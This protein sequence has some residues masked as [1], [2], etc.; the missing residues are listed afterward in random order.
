VAREAFD[1]LIDAQARLEQAS[2]GRRYRDI[3][4]QSA[5]EVLG[6]D[7]SRAAMLADTVDIWPPFDDSS[8]ALARLARVAPLVALT[9]S[10]R[11]H[12]AAV[13]SALGGP[14]VVPWAHWLCAEDTGVYKPDPRVWDACAAA[15]GVTAGPAW[16]HVSAYADYDLDVASR[17]GLTTVYVERPH[18]RP[19]PARWTIPDLTALARL[20]ESDDR[21]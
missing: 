3:V 5:Q 14:D 15:T 21:G 7:P 18:R 4:A 1:A 16:W 8:A 9:N 12:G 19:G 17:R 11:D 2:P 10:D 20:L 6:L 13:R